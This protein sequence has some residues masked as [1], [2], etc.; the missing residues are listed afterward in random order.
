MEVVFALWERFV[1]RNAERHVSGYDRAQAAMTNARER[2]A[3]SSG[4]F[5]IRETTSRSALRGAS[6]TRTS[7]DG[8]NRRSWY[9]RLAA[10]R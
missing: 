4:I 2:H 3:R 9:A 10:R 8:C 7:P 6:G 5:L 1:S